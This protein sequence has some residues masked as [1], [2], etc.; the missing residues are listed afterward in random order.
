MC[1][2]DP[3]HGGHRAVRVHARPVHQEWAGLRGGVLAH[4]PPDVP[5]HKAHEGA[6]HARQGQG[7]R[8]H[9]A[10][11]QQGGSGAPA[12]GAFTRGRSA[13]A[14]VGLSL[15]GGLGQEPYQRQRDVRGDRA[16]DE[17]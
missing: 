16:R 13:G 2:G 8:A 1:V 6:D 9:S 14:A 3:R 5:G 4:Q 12:R 17:L 15:R 10:G 7:A 11:G